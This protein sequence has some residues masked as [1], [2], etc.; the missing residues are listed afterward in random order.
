MLTANVRL[1]SGDKVVVIGAGGFIGKNIASRLER[2]GIYVEKIY[3][4]N[5]NL[6]EPDSVNFLQEKFCGSAAV[7][8]LACITP[9]KGRGAEVFLR[10]V[11][12]AKNVVE[13]LKTQAEIPHF[14]Y[15]SSDAVYNFDS[16]LVSEK[17]L[18]SPVDLYGAMHRSRELM[19][20]E[21]CKDRLAVIRPTLVYGEGDTHNSY[22]PNRLRREAFRDGSITLFGEGEDTRSHV[23][24]DDLVEL[25]WLV[26]QK[27]F[28]GV[29]NAAPDVSVTYAELAKKVSACFQKP[30]IIKSKPRAAEPNHRFF[31]ATFCY[32]SFPGFVFTPLEEG[33][34]ITINSMEKNPNA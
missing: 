1:R 13:A 2:E 31:D 11:A 25:T 22:G 32:E 26:L 27:E 30:S 8:M 15:F 12:M 3:S 5:L 21:F 10:N 17:T 19:F 18:A 33:L 23:F 4:A 7:I 9:D 24:I 29:L 20:E 28:V 34:E 6:V 16:S 14:I